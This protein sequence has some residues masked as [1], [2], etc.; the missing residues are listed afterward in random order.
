MFHDMFVGTWHQKWMLG[1]L[2]CSFFDDALQYNQISNQQSKTGSS[3]P[4]TLES[5]GA[6]VRG[7]SR[8]VVVA[9]GNNT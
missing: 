8:I 2:G 4:K 3:Q 9:Q 5:F 6:F 7:S 1:I